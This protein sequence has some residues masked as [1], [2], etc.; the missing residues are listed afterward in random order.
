MGHATQPMC[1]YPCMRFRALLPRRAVHF[2]APTFKWGISIA[3]IADLQRPPEKISTPQQ[4]GASLSCMARAWRVRVR[5]CALRTRTAAA[6]VKGGT[7]PGLGEWKHQITAWYSA[8]A[9]CSAWGVTV[10][11]GWSRRWGCRWAC[12]YW[13]SGCLPAAPPAPPPAPE[14]GLFPAAAVMVAAAAQSGAAAARTAF[15]DAK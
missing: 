3:N 5:L 4:L 15:T 1:T 12:G 6:F 2:W 8:L 14:D 10:R 9:Q 11:D 13:T 7:Q